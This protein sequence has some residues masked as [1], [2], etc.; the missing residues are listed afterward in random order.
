[1]ENDLLIYFDQKNFDWTIRSLND[2]IT[3]AGEV[4]E[5]YN[6]LKTPQLK[7]GEFTRLLFDTDNFLFEKLMG[8]Q[9]AE[10]GGMQ[11]NKRT[12]YDQFL[13]KP[14]GYSEL[15]NAINIFIKRTSF[16]AKRYWNNLDVKTY[17]LA[18]FSPLD[19]GNF[20]LKE[21][22][23]EDERKRNEVYVKSERAKYAYK[24]ALDL[25]KLLNEENLLREIK[26]STNKNLGD[27][28]KEMFLPIEPDKKEVEI[29]IEFIRQ[30]D[31]RTF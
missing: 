7:K 19:N 21:R 14:E 5:L 29:N 9:P 25:Q 23:I 18:F 2:T 13:T 11:I 30:L 16:T 17:F 20:E 4:I 10:F 1:M 27:F 6:R 24:L 3:Y 22:V 12:F 28:I 26:V 31:S 15:I 8:N